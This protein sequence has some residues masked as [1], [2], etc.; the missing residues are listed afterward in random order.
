MTLI[1]SISGIRGTIG[2]R[3]GEGLTP[4]DIVKFTSA[5]GTWAVKKAGLKKI[6]VGRDARISGSMVNNLVIGSLQ[7]LGI[8][9]IDLGLST[10]PTVE[11]AVPGEKAA[12]GIII[13]AS[14]NPKQWNALKLLNAD[15]EF[16]SDADGK[17]VLQIAEDSDFNY[18]DV[19]DLGKVTV[20]DTWMQKH[21][22]AIL[23]LPLVDVKAIQKANFSVV[24]DCVNSTGGIFV[25]ALLDALGVKTVHPLYCEPDGKFPHNPEPLP[26]NL[27]ELSREVVAKKAQLGI[28]V[29]PD[30]DRLCFV[31]EDGSMFGEEYTLVAV[32]DY[33]LKH[34]KGNTVSNLSSTRALRDVTEAAGCTYEAAAVGEV[35][36]VNKMKETNAI[37]GGEGNGGVI[38]PEL[39]YGRDALVGIALFLTHLAKFGKSVS[40]LRATY[41]GYF[42]SKN[43]ITLTPEM[44][45][46]VLLQK[47]EEKYKRQ[48]HSTIDGLKIEFDK[49]WVHLRRSNTE[50]IIRI[51]SEGNSETVA[52]NLANKIIA[53]IK[54]ILQIS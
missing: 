34:A 29:D 3:A 37:I 15:G 22:D 53:D 14:H 44:D 31:A 21:I 12:G 19:N 39:H 42:I 18:A 8:D 13:T 35:N 41:P 36:V 1:K 28:A 2:G 9:V 27:T 54:E 5:F 50:P 24:I 33:V 45:I 43:K 40:R 30:V 51:Y 16:I 47:V 52:N 48:P 38:Y 6:V 23:A 7:G 11:V 4:L 49:E 25:P 20:D 17:E 26:E 32:A 10:T 46:D